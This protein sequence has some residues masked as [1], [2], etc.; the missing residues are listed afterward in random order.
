MSALDVER[1][2]RIARVGEDVQ[3]ALPQGAR[4]RR[5]SD[6]ENAVHG[7]GLSARIDNRHIT[8]THHHD[9]NSVIT[10][11]RQ[12][13]TLAGLAIAPRSG[14]AAWPAA[15]DGTGARLALPAAERRQ[16]ARQQRAQRAK[17]ALVNFWATTCTTCVAEMPELIR[18]HQKFQQRGFET[19]AVA[20]SYDPVE[21]VLN[22]SRSRQLPF[23]VALDRNGD[24]ARSWGDVKAHADHLPARQAG[25]DRQALRR[26]TR[27]RGAAP[28]DRAV[29][30]QA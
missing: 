7:T 3:H 22:Y 18:T 20:M 29:A 6:D 14:W 2:Q 30:G 5:M 28:A 11:R 17:V 19:V 8:I 1:D 23:R 21:W 25:P 27:L 12:A 13:L 9:M 15:A 10:D 4:Q 26:R 16:H 24:L